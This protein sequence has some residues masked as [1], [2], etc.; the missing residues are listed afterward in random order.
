MWQFQSDYIFSL[1]YITSQTN[2]SFESI[3][4]TREEDRHL[5]SGFISINSIPIEETH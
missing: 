4:E 5:H 1:F 3:E 2:Q